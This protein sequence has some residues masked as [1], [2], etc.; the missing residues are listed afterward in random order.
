MSQEMA[1]VVTFAIVVAGG[2]TIVISGMRH[3]ARI[4]EMMHKERIAM[5][6]KGIVPPP[7]R[8]PEAFDRTIRQRR[9]VGARRLQ[10]LAVITIGFGMALALL[11]TVTAGTADVGLGIGGAIIVLGTALLINARLAAPEEQNTKDKEQRTE[12]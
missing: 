2:L 10:S 9:T 7:E 3:R 8:D 12:L 11:I 4:L 5:I 6:E 1:V